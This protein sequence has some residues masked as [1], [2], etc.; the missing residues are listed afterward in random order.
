MN[1]NYCTKETLERRLK[2]VAYELPQHPK[3]IR[4][5]PCLCANSAKKWRCLYQ[6][7]IVIV[8][9]YMQNSQLSEKISDSWP[10]VVRIIKVRSF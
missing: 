3:T 1:G 4:E 2:G 6:Y 8:S 10:F 5:Q 9:A 7:F